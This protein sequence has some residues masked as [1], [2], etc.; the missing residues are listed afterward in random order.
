MEASLALVVSAALLVVGFD[1]ATYAA[2]G[3]SLIV[4][5]TN[6]ANKATTLK[7]TTGGAVLS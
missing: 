4:G 5:K 7:R 3:D 2:T 6:K 1:L